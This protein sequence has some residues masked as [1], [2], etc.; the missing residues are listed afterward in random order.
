MP[1]PS[2]EY[3][4]APAFLAAAVELTE[5]YREAFAGPPWDETPD[6]IQAFTDGLPD[7]T[8]RDGFTGAWIRDDTGFAG[9]AFRVRTPDPL[10][11]TGFYGI[12]RDRFGAG[13][14][15]L[16]GAAEVVEL[17]VRPAHRGR[18]F[19]RT[20]L[21]AVTAGERAWLVTRVAAADTIAFYHRLGWR[22]HATT[23]GLVILT[24]SAH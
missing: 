5:T 18:G 10:P 15:E 13:V 2:P 9:F 12:L 6:Q 16:G 11:A 22:D 23:D 8:A 24:H 17:A 1:T 4:D 21:E 7:W 19:G 3:A 20:L 14:D